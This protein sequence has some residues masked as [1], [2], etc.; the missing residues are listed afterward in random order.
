MEKLF[1]LFNEIPIS[2][3]YLLFSILHHITALPA[4]GGGGS[5]PM[6]FVCWLKLCWHVQPTG[7]RQLLS[8]IAYKPVLVP[9]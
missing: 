5:L 3:L 4:W 2:E 7:N 6:L 1:K 9:H 8:V